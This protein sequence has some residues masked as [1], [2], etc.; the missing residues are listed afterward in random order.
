MKDEEW[1]RDS[2]RE[3]YE[4]EG[5]IEV[6]YDASVSI[7]EDGKGAYVQAWVWVPLGEDES[8]SDMLTPEPNRAISS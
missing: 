5:R 1:I 8:D 6:D 7:G 3:L 2:A 4:E